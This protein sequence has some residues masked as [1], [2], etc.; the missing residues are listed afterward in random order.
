M[1]PANLSM[2]E[3]Y[4]ARG[5]TAG[6]VLA[7]LLLALL[8]RGLSG[9]QSLY[10]ILF[11]ASSAFFAFLAIAGGLQYLYPH[12]SIAEPGNNL[13]TCFFGFAALAMLWF[14]G[15][16]DQGGRLLK[17]IG[18]STPAGTVRTSSS[19]DSGGNGKSTKPAAHAVLDPETSWTAHA[20]T[21]RLAPRGV[22]G[23]KSASRID[24]LIATKCDAGPAKI[25][26]DFRKVTALDPAVVQAI[27]DC[28]RRYPA[29]RFAFVAT[30]DSAPYDKLT[31]LG[32]DQMISIQPTLSS[33]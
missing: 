13:I 24:N 4:A 31:L 17:S 19:L 3:G 27:V 10:R 18:E 6:F 8:A 14:S 21:V 33:R 25:V 5:H 11:G 29:S 2:L 20:E 23:S 22:L 1:T 28:Y 9:D 30:P 7:G 12:G 32:I 26:L 15:L 16:L